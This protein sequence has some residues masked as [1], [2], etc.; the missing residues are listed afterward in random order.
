MAAEPGSPKSEGESKAPVIVDMGDHAANKARGYP[1]NFIRT[2]KYSIITFLP[3]NLFHQFRKVSNFYF[4]VNMI[5]AL[6]PGVSPINPATAV[7]P[8]L[9]VIG[10]A[11]AKD[12]YEDYCRHQ[13]DN[14]ANSITT[15]IL[16][17]QKD[18]TWHRS[19]MESADVEVGDIVYMQNGEEVRADVLLLSSTGQECAAFIDTCNLDGET[20]LKN[21]KAV[22]ETWHLNN[23]EIL[24]KTHLEIK[25]GVPNPGLHHWTGLVTVDGKEVAVGLDQFLYRSCILKNTEH[26]W[27][28]VVYAGQDTKMFKNLQEKPPKMSSLDHK[29]NILILAVL[30]VQ[31]LLLIIMSSLALWFNNK[32]ENDWYLRYYIADMTG[33]ELWIMRYLTYFILMSYLIPISLFVT[34][35]LCKVAQAQ[36]MA[37]DH[38]MFEW[39][40]ERWVHCVA[41]TSNLNEQL[42]VIKFIF[43]DKTGTLTE[44]VMT[45][46]KGDVLGKPIDADHWAISRAYMQSGASGREEASQ[47]FHLLALCHTIQPFDDPK[48]EGRLMYDGASPD[49]VALVKAAVEHGIVLI[50]RSVRTMTLDVDGKKE[51][52]EILATL[53]FTPDRKMMSIILRC[54]DGTIQVYTKGADSFVIPRLHP[55]A[56]ER[57]LPS[58]NESLREAASEGLR[59]LIVCG[60]TI[61]QAEFDAW[62]ARFMEAGKALEDRSAI[63][64]KICLEMEKDLMMI[65]ITAIEDRLQDK[66]PETLQ[67][68]LS[69]GVIVWM[70]TGDKRETAV[71]IAA[72]SSLANPQEDY[73]EHVDIGALLP[74]DE[75]AVPVVKRQLDK[76]QECLNR[77]DKRVSFVIDGPA[78][79]VAMS[80]HIDQFLAISQK[81]NSA[82]CC[83]LTP[84]QKANVV[85]MFQT[86]TGQTALAIGDGANDVSMIQEGRV[87]VGI[88]GLEGAQAAL[89]ADYAIPR[90]KHL[91]RLCCVHGRYAVA[92]NSLCIAYSFYKNTI[93]ALLQF[94]YSF[95]AG[96]SGQTLMDGW[97]LAFYNFAF[98]SFPPLFLGIFDKDIVEDA[99]MEHPDLFPPLAEGLYFDIP[100]MARWFGEGI[101]HTLVLFYVTYPTM[102]RQDVQEHR[103]MD[104]NMFGT[105]LM[106]STIYLVLTK[107]VLHIRYWQAFQV[108]GF[109]FSYLLYLGFILLYAAIPSLFGD[110]IFYYST[111]TLMQDAKFWMYLFLFVVGML[112]P[113]DVAIMFLQRQLFPTAMDRVAEKYEA[114]E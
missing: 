92:R 98:T 49:E 34:I 89:A 59:T 110:T 35:E 58:S 3:L 68:F 85:N 32:H 107:L 15:H 84:L 43:S 48:H 7:L 50:E 97:L 91:R 37:W 114:I 27:G 88:M 51:K 80:H 82:V 10:V 56:N 78:L 61:T 112:F 66:V 57:V 69:A 12:G 54:P 87:G 96:F 101:V 79:N 2:S 18:G 17:K 21:R 9:F 52:F 1:S 47:Y 53:E 86:K 38:N 36:L 45:Y 100:T 72:T 103:I 20:N 60:K 104:V 93:I 14:R 105:L 39:M 4:L 99:L 44:N 6:I 94:I 67:F 30:F 11:L 46:K 26:A 55:T 65:G 16:R 95:Y 23:E 75:K 106:T 76:V 33:G 22:E 5:I 111:Y 8:L 63:V 25:T 70:L 13:N 90:F 62:N 81:V 40:Y 31:N 108:G 24:Q 109:V 83:R 19:E 28:V 73:I 74:E 29:L 42:A 113:I 77:G 102:L 71:T 64:D 41:N